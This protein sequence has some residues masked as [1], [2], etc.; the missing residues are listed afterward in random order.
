M[1]SESRLWK[2]VSDMNFDGSITGRD[3][4]LWLKWLYFC[5]GDLFVLLLIKVFPGYTHFLR[6]YESLSTMILSFTLSLIIWILVFV[7]IMRTKGLL[8]FHL[9][10]YHKDNRVNKIQ[11]FFQEREVKNWERQNKE[12]NRMPVESEI[13]DILANNNDNHVSS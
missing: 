6:N 11:K 8:K 12:S 5:P 10:R 2:F 3:V 7:L 9:K 13:N 4:L 1:D